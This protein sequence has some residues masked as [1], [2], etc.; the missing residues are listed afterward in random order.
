MNGDRRRTVPLGVQLLLLFGDPLAKFGWVF[1]GVGFIFFWI[2]FPE[3]GAQ[4][5]SAA[6]TI[7][8][9]VI[10]AFVVVSAVCIV[11]GFRNGA[12]SLA[13]LTKGQLAYGYLRTIVPLREFVNDRQALQVTYSFATPDGVSHEMSMKTQ[14]LRCMPSRGTVAL[15]DGDESRKLPLPFLEHLADE[16]RE[17]LLFDSAR[18]ENAVAIS[19]LHVRLSL[20]NDGRFHGRR[21]GEVLC[22]LLP[23]GVTLLAHGFVAYLRFFA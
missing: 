4:T 5:D 1:L 22:G 2:F 19:N 9:V 8:S 11:I 23:I 14:H 3:S 20:G 13:L 17:I 15:I 18:P 21:A 7:P 10:G 12:R 6:M 16:G